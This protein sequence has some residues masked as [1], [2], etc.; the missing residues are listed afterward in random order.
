VKVGGRTYV[1]TINGNPR[2][3][4]A[5]N[6]LTNPNVP[7]G[8]AAGFVVKAGEAW[9]RLLSA[10]YTTLS[11]AFIVS[12]FLRDTAYS[13]QMVWVRESPNYALRFNKNYLRVNPIMMR[14]LFGKWE[15][16][17]LDDGKPLEKHFRDFML[18][19]G[20]TGYAMAQDINDYKKKL[21]KELR[22]YRRSAWLRGGGIL[23]EQYEML[24]RAVENCARF[25]AYL[26]S[27][28]MGRSA[29]RSAFDAKEISVNFNKKGAG[30][31]TFGMQGQSLVGNV[32]SLISGLGRI[33]FTFWNAGVQGMAN[34]GRGFKRHPFK[35]ALLAAGPLFTM[36]ALAPVVARLMGAG[37]GDDDDKD[38]YYNLPE[39]VRRSNV[40]IYVG[41]LADS[42]KGTWLEKFLHGTYLA[43]PLPIEF[44]S[45]YG[46]GE[47]TYGVVSGNERYSNEELAMQYASQFS[48]L[49]PIDMLEGS[50]GFHAFIPTF[51]KPYVEAEQ[52][53]S[54]SGTPIYRDSEWNKDDPQ[55]TKAFSNA[56]EYIVNGTE[57]L[58][59]MSGGDEYKQGWWDWNPAKIEYM[60]RGYL[61]G[62]YTFPT[63]MLRFGETVTGARDFEWRNVPLANRVLKQA[64]ER[65]ELRK[66]KNDFYRMRDEAERTG[67][68][69]EKYQK[70]ERGG[71]Y[72]YDAKLKDLQ[73]S[74]EYGR[75]LIYE[76]YK[77]LLAA[78]KDSR[79]G[80]DEVSGKYLE[81]MERRLMRSM[82]DAI[83]AYDD[84]TKVD[85]RATSDKLLEEA[86]QSGIAALSKKANAEQAKRLGG[87]DTYGSSNKEY[88]QIYT[89]KRDYFDLAEDTMLQSELHKAKEAGD[90]ERAK[91]IDK[92]RDELTAIRKGVHTKTKDVP[93]FGEEGGDDEEIMARLRARR[94]EL[95][96]ELGI[97][98]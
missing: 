6:G 2:A 22:N 78:V 18:N 33:L 38:A 24:G 12:N 73:G 37:D 20:E 89:A 60:L 30:G 54:W 80:A 5:L 29:M 85:S 19:G 46:L 23:F 77:P 52:N 35:A 32:G 48:Q 31:K 95:L 17:T 92:A 63:E 51:A 47:L 82:V 70:A 7:I 15:S 76:D 34:F 90:T 45:L 41:G 13:N 43:L 72:D 55:W 57:W 71:K 9:N 86:S 94:K 84:G 28:E 53:M 26:T 59:A 58:N 93:G 88:N 36:G 25:A 56:N 10:L 65:T 69:E 4:Q 75:Y 74:Q 79:K 50:G 8:G 83:H 98:R 27:R 81:D 44:R 42:V 66:L 91:R 1:L 14:V 68:L 21:K 97:T 96:R 67:K 39:Y 61:G 62:L 49:L 87:E 40:C 3:A 11:P 16:G 64:D